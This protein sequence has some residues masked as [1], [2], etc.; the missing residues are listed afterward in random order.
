MHTAIY[1]KS[2]GEVCNDNN[3][4]TPPIYKQI[5]TLKHMSTKNILLTILSFIIPIVGIIIYF[6]Q[7]QKDEYAE[8]YLYAAI[9]SMV[10]GFFIG[11]LA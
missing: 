8:Y 6:A 3:T 7:R 2:T 11:L 9:A 10:G 4:S 5:E 1:S